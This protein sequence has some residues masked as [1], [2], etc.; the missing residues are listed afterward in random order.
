MASSSADGNAW[1]ARVCASFA[2][3]PS[4]R[5]KLNSKKEL[6]GEALLEVVRLFK[7]HVNEK[8]LEDKDILASSD[9]YM[10]PDNKGDNA[11]KKYLVDLVLAGERLRELSFSGTWRCQLLRE[12]P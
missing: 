9:L 8:I 11:D 4:V 7:W 12:L 2:A 6:K 3:E 5:G 10:T 1:M